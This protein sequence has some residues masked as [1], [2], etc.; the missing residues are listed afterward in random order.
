MLCL[1]SNFMR[2]G[3]AGCPFKLLRFVCSLSPSLAFVYSSLLFLSLSVYSST[4]PFFCFILVLSFFLPLSCLLSLPLSHPICLFLPSS[5]SHFIPSSMSPFLPSYI[6]LFLSSS[7]SLFLPSSISLFL[8]SSI[9]V[10]SFF[11]FI[12]ALSLD[13]SSLSPLFPSSQFHSLLPSF[14]PLFFS[15]SLPL[16]FSPSLH[17]F[18][19][20]SLPPLSS[21][22]PFPFPLLEILSL[23]FPPSLI[24]SFSF[25]TFPLFQ[26]SFL[27]LVL[28]PCLPRYEPQ[29]DHAPASSL[30]DVAR[31]TAKTSA[32]PP[33]NLWRWR[34]TAGPVRE[35][36]DIF[37]SFL[38]SL[39]YLCLYFFWSLICV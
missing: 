30:P 20:S 18:L 13:P 26:I 19:L 23:S 37:S 1:L 21:P 22:A 5:I 33:E 25:L 9:S 24:L 39:L 6:S 17:Y 35:L 16:S 12:F 27:S 34:E 28:P 29:A 2:R 4:F 15:R 32:P 14:L 38:Q 31:E 36:F 7:I 11:H 10:S 8:S 3:L